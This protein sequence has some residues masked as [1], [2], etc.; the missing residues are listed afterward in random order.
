MTAGLLACAGEFNPDLS[1]LDDG[2]SDDGG[3]PDD[4]DED[5]GSEDDGDGVPPDVPSDDGGDDGSD[6]GTSDDGS[7][8][9]GTSDGGDDG[10]T[11][12]DTGT[13][14][15][16]TETLPDEP[17][18]GDLCYPPYENCP[19]NFTCALDMDDPDRNYR[20]LTFTGDTGEPGSVCEGTLTT[21]CMYGHCASSDWGPEGM[22]DGGAG[23]L[24]CLPFCNPSLNDADCPAGSHCGGTNPDY[25]PEY[26][27]ELGGLGFCNTL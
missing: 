1:G 17:Q 21:N 14:S 15:D 18:E 3:E 7:S 20:C 4:G 25:L 26:V 9:T 27:L 11:D 13:S 22:C 23:T 12:S 2:A 5:G 6:D 24:C 8:D 10:G 19:S 16:G